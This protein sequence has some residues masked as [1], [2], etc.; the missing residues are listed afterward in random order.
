MVGCLL[1]A[2]SGLR[3]LAPK[4]GE[5]A[6]GLGLLRHLQGILHL[7]PEVSDRALEL[8]MPEQDLDGPQVLRAS[9]YERRLGPAHAVRSICMAVQPDSGDPS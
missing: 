5:A 4:A 8:G 1:L 7:D 9:V 2:G 3:R 6:L